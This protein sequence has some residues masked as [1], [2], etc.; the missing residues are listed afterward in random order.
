[1]KIIYFLSWILLSFT[2]VFAQQPTKH[3]SF[4]DSL[5]G[6]FDLSNFIIEKN[7]FIPVPY[8]VT[9]PALGG[10]GGAI[11]PVFIKKK[12]P[13]I[14]S[15]KGK[16]VR[17]PV[18]PDITGGVAAY[19]ANKTRMLA[20]FRSGTLVKSRIKYIIGGGYANINMAFYRTLPSVGEQKFEFNFRSVPIMLQAIKRIGFSHWYA[21]FKYLF[22]KSDL[23]YTGTLP[24]FVKQKDISSLVSQ[25]GAVVELDTRDNVFTPD[26]GMKVHFDG[27]YSGNLIGSDYDFWRL[28]YYVYGYKSLSKK[29]VLGLRF[30][31]QQSLG[32]APFYML[33]YIDMRG[34]PIEKYQG[35]A[36]VLAEF[37]TR[38]DVVERWS[39]VAFGGTGK[40][41]DEWSEFKNSA[42]IFSYGAGFR[43]LIA[44]KFKLRV[45]VDVAHGPGT[46]A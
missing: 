36:D 11:A 31:G 29:F 6:A 23:K 45:G 8:I 43:Y 13:Y 10:F 38:W 22:L 26:N 17:T 33:P 27:I 20:A 44:R 12:P 42:W 34:I 7:G 37:E 18:A 15:I 1:M 35:N 4:K 9:E 46:W 28:N 40:A 39:A 24:P 30:D 14:D 41:F 25:L 2:C 32:N 3:I 16:V 5:D 21:G 19:T